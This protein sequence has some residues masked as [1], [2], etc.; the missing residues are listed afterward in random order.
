[1][2]ATTTTQAPTPLPTPPPIEQDVKPTVLPSPTTEST[3]SLPSGEEPNKTP[4][5]PQIASSITLNLSAS[6]PP[7]S[8]AT[9]DAARAAALLLAAVQRLNAVAAARNAQLANLH[10]AQ[11]RRCPTVPLVVPEVPM[12]KLDLVLN[13]G[14]AAAGKGKT[15]VIFAPVR[16]RTAETEGGRLDPRRRRV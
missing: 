3:P 6:N 7:S 13:V 16:K 11:L 9:T 15:G 4:L 2:A 12:V 14:A 10:A 5:P 8:S 1:M